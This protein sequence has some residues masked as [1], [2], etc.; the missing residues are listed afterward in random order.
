MG[1]DWS[2][3]NSEPEKAEDD[4]IPLDIHQ[5]LKDFLQIEDK[6]YVYR[7]SEAYNMIK[8]IAEHADTTQDLLDE[9]PEVP[10]LSEK[11]CE[12]LKFRYNGKSENESEDD[13]DNEQEEYS[14]DLE[15]WIPGENDEESFVGQENT[16]APTR[17]KA[18]EEVKNPVMQMETSF[19]A[20]G[21]M[22]RTPVEL[23]NADF[24]YDLFILHKEC[25]VTEAL[26]M[27]KIKEM[28]KTRRLEEQ[29][30]STRHSTKHVT[31]EPKE[32]PHL[33]QDLTTWIDRQG[34][35]FSK[36]ATFEKQYVECTQTFMVEYTSRSEENKK[37]Y[38]KLFKATVQPKPVEDQFIVPAIDLK[39]TQFNH[40]NTV[41]FFQ[42]RINQ[43][44]PNMP[45]P[46]LDSLLHSNNNN[47]VSSTQEQQQP[48]FDSFD[49]NRIEI[50]LWKKKFLE[51]EG[52]AHQ[53]CESLLKMLA[54]KQ[55]LHD[56]I[57]EKT[58]FPNDEKLSSITKKRLKDE[59]DVF[60]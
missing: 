20:N 2:K 7:G 5:P 53:R 13:D 49:H 10:I 48:H 55:R 14:S 46:S 60:Y 44:Q 34:K 8:R 52:W 21:E 30:E 22:P 15:E 56:A 4:T 18:D 16:P 32:K 38:D 36:Y 47:N 57:L 35:H 59:E 25:I 39:N 26:I 1:G 54:Q 3:E 58:K 33:F 29:L 43:F 12:A 6:T 24:Y 19:F 9:Y 31:F 41:P 11:I 28:E 40:D 45:P 42:Q 50:E 23:K 37:L 17:K 27:E 51:T